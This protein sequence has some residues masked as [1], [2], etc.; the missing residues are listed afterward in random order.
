MRPA[1]HPGSLSSPSEPEGLFV[2]LSCHQSAGWVGLLQVGGLEGGWG[3][4]RGQQPAVSLLQLTIV[5]CH[6]I[7]IGKG[8]C[9]RWVVVFSL[10]SSPTVERT[11]EKTTTKGIRPLSVANQH[12]VFQQRSM[13]CTKCDKCA[14]K[15]NR[16]Y[17]ATIR[18]LEHQ[19]TPL[20]AL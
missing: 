5:Q 4:G 1:P 13:G 10:G 14:I 19:Q 9:L 18:D 6:W 3:G 15:H 12:W 20:T 17:F 8:G 7:E 2:R 11:S 16:N